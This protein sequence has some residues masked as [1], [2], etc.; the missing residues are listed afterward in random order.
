MKATVRRIGVLTSGGDAP[1]MNACLR[2]VVRSAIANGLSVAGI[3]RGYAGL[4]EGDMVE[5]HAGSVSNIIHNGGTILKTARCEEFKTEEGRERAASVLRENG[6]EGLVTVGGDGTLRGAWAFRQEHSVPLVAAPST[7]DGGL[8]GTDAT[9]GFDTALNIALEAVDRIRDTAASHERL[10][11]IEVMGRDMG[12]LG[13]YCGLAGGAEGVL[14]PEVADS[15]D[16]LAEKIMAGRE[17]GKTSSIVIV[18]EGDEEGGAYQVAHEMS[19]L[20]GLEYRVCILG[21][22]QRGGSPTARDRV[23]ASRLGAGA[24][25]G[26]LEGKDCHLVGEVNGAIAFTHLSEVAGK[27]RPIDLSA[28]H[29]AEVL[30]T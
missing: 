12:L 9:I 6:I 10:F 5:M 30:S 1:G 4:I 22:V 14:I 15:L 24:V 28:Y 25:E 8:P 11:F 26:L 3:R 7:I 2:A 23:L 21:H 20:T 18:S 13:M 27:R 16:L 29:L 17:R 19:E